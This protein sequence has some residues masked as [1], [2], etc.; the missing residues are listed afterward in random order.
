MTEAHHDFAFGSIGLSEGIA[1]ILSQP[2]DRIAGR[3]SSAAFS[4][5]KLCR[6]LSRTSVILAPRFYQA[7]ILRWRI[8]FRCINHRVE[9]E[10]VPN[11]DIVD[12]ECSRY[13]AL[14]NHSKN[15]VLP[16]PRYAAASSARKPLGL[17]KWLCLCNPLGISVSTNRKTSTKCGA[18]PWFVI[19][20]F[21]GAS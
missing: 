15:F 6:Y 9:I 13:C 17:I 11:L 7:V 21:V 1:G 8:F 12:C 18:G 19:L 14:I 4:P 2:M 10:P 5:R 20:K 3:P 16:I